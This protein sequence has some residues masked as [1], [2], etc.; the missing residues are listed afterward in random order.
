MFRI[1]FFLNSFYLK[2]KKKDKKCN[3]NI[4][5]RFLNLL[6]NVD[7]SIGIVVVW[8]PQWPRVQISPS[9]SKVKK[10]SKNGPDM[11]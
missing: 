3:Q 4:D 7:I 11:L 6:L 1:H 2:K 10:R 5:A 8:A 9:F